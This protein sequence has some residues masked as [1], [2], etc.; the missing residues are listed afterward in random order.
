MQNIKKYTRVIMLP[1]TYLVMSDIV[2]TSVIWSGQQQP[3]QPW[4]SVWQR[5]NLTR[6]LFNERALPLCP[7]EKK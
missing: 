4:L 7:H 5:S 6:S 2:F 3:R 1:V